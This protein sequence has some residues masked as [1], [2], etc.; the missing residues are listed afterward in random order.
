[1]KEQKDKKQLE[2]RI[3]KHNK[4]SNK[5]KSISDQ[6]LYKLLM[7]A[8]IVKQGNGT[9]LN[10][11]I[12]GTHVFAKQIPLTDLENKAENIGSTANLFNL[13]MYYQYGV[14]STGFG[15]WRELTVHKKVNDWVL[16]GECE[17]F[18]LMYESRIIP[19]LPK[20]QLST[21]QIETYTE[22]WGGS[23]SIR[24]K[25]N[26]INNSESAITLFVEYI[27]YTLDKWI[28]EQLKNGS[29][30]A[31]KTINMIENNLNQTI[32]FMNSKGMLHFDATRN[33]IL[34]DGQRLYFSDF[35]LSIF[36]TFNLSK[37]ENDFFNTH[38]NYDQCE[39]LWFVC[40][41]IH[42]FYQIMYG[43]E[44]SKRIYVKPAQII[45]FLKCY[46]SIAM[47]MEKFFNA[48]RADKTKTVPFPVDEFN[49]LCLE[50]NINKNKL[51]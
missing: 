18:P 20:K 42:N 30:Y 2:C 7:Q 35:G 3:E 49:M 27:P 23:D 46:S 19:M 40:G 22:Y 31:S 15:A 11:D 25:L 34:T 51:K 4:I 21:S 1:L 12:E 8:S 33:N 17:N 29:E 36:S 24:T 39:T 47:R 5:L 44:D 28:D 14:G 38:K 45:K 13:P 9:T 16:N 26:A 41:K 43:L 10:L 50:A 32:E 6:K 37:E 48:L